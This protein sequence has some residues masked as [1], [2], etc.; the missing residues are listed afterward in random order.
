MDYMIIHVYTYL[1]MLKHTF[2]RTFLQ[3]CD[4]NKIQY[5]WPLDLFSQS[6]K[7]EPTVRFKEVSK[8]TG[9]LHF[10]ACLYPGEIIL[11]GGQNEERQ[12]M[13][14]VERKR[15]AYDN[16]TTTQNILMRGAAKFDLHVLNIPLAYLTNRA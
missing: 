2:T 15:V 14:S 12:L 1:N 11:C 5:S 10:G 8:F 4:L 13:N 9:R 16:I 6:Q 3:N 7:D